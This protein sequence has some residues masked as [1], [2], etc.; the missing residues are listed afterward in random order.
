M[1]VLQR[2]TTIVASSF[3]DWE[4]V[5]RQQKST[6]MDDG[7]ISGV[8]AGRGVNKDQQP[9]NP[10]DPARGNRRYSGLSIPLIFSVA[11]YTSSQVE[12]S[13]RPPLNSIARMKRSNSISRL[14]MI[15]IAI[16]IYCYSPSP[17]S[18]LPSSAVPRKTQPSEPRTTCMTW[19]IQDQK[20]FT[21]DTDRLREYMPSSDRNGCARQP[22]RKPNRRPGAPEPSRSAGT[23]YQFTT[24]V[25]SLELVLG[26]NRSI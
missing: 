7:S 1:V 2:Y 4:R 24:T 9:I 6:V 21:Y 3:E 19:M 16:Y 10:A 22:C 5:H 26:I 20:Q 23:G 8:E 14:L 15:A 18:S 12:P 25:R 11:K 13:P 17:N